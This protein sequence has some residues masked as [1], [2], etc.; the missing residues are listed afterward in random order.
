MSLKFEFVDMLGSP[1]TGMKTLKVSMIS[2]SDASKTKV[3]VTKHIVKDKHLA[4][5]TP[6]L[7][8]LKSG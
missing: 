4:T 7:S 2:F 6:S 1:Y 3:D 8:D 5:F